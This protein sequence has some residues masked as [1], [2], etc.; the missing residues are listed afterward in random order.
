MVHTL[1]NA[2]IPS[3]QEFREKFIPSR[4]PKTCFLSYNSKLRTK[5]STKVTV[6]P[7]PSAS[8]RNR[9]STSFR[10]EEPLIVRE[11]SESFI[12]FVTP[13]WIAERFGADLMRGK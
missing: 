7:A 6:P 11:M 13:M 2:G 8:L 12:F 3:Y 9:R 10:L 4:V 1:T 5:S